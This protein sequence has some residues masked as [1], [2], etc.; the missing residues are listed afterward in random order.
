MAHTVGNS[1]VVRGLRGGR[2]GQ[3]PG[4]LPLGGAAQGS[5][6]AD[7]SR[8]GVVQSGDDR[9]IGLPAAEPRKRGL[10]PL[11]APPRQVR[12]PACGN[13][14]RGAGLLTGGAPARVRN[15]EPEP[16]PQKPYT[17]QRTLSPV[18]EAASVL[19]GRAPGGGNACTE[20]RVSDPCVGVKGFSRA[21]GGQRRILKCAQT[22]KM[23][24]N[25]NCRKC[26]FDKNVRF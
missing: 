2:A 6:A 5:H 20:D 26:P 17:H 9:G 15:P 12:D 8:R 24:L 21:G 14:R 1:P 22:T 10:P 23:C 19:F 7:R 4:D 25:N 13:R 16:L 3:Y 11:A 18:A